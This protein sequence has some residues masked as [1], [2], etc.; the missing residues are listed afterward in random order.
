VIDRERRRLSFGSVAALYERY[1]PGYPTEAVAWLLG[2]GAR[3]VLDLGAGTGK[4]TR[5]LLAAGHDVVAI[6]PDA[7]MRAELAARLPGVSLHAGTAE[8][9]PLPDASVD[10]VAMGQAFHW[11]D[12][13]AALPEIA[14]VLRPGGVLAVAW[15]LRDDSAGWAAELTA[16]TDGGDST[17]DAR[18]ET[19]SFGER[20]G[21]V[22]RAWF[23]NVFPVDLDGLAGLVASW[24]FTITRPAEERERILADVRALG[25]RV[26]GPDGTI[27]VPYVTVCLRAERA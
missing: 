17:R 25:R 4:L 5:A 1:R 21:P 13:D 15:N 16:V 6:E 14:R 19:R 7:E 3:R 10:A 20:F 8:Q 26:A 9:I 18:E 11:I 22:E 12:P 24:S 27:E 2:P 23:A